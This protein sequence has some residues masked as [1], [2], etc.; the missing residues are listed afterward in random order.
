MLQI[1]ITPTKLYF[2]NLNDALYQELKQVISLLND[3]KGYYMEDTPQALYKTLL[4]LS[5][6][7]DIE[8]Y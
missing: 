2:N 5:Y 3:S 4:K 1:T 6:T 7:Y 8:I